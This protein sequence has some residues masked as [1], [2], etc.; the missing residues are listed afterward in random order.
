M[1][2]CV[3]IRL[4]IKAQA[5]SGKLI[6]KI[7]KSKKYV[8]IPNETKRLRSGGYGY[9]CGSGKERKGKETFE[10]SSAFSTK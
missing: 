1:L 6:N 4:E 8:K 3:G 10:C 5:L 9:G 2:N 7:K